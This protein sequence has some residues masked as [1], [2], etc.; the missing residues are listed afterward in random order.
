[1]L[2]VR[3][4]LEQGTLRGREWPE[5]DPS[6]KLIVVTAHRHES[7]GDGFG[8]IC[9]ALATIA[10]RDPH[11]RLIEP[12]SYVPFVDLMPRAYLLSPEAV[13]AGTVKLVGTDEGR[14]VGEATVW[15]DNREA[16]NDMSRV[17]NPYGDGRASARISGLIDS[18][19]SSTS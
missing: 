9:R 1:M 19:L 14:I 12:Q 18:F 17:H 6:K 11:M 13:T 16:Y 2:Y 7:F 8:R 4:R 3:D 10:D 15:L 5:L